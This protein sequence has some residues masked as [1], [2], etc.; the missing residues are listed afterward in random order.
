MNFEEE[1]KKKTGEVKKILAAYLPAPEGFQSRVLE[2]MEYAVSAGGKRERP[3]LMAETA[4]LFGE[5]GESLS[6][7]MADR[8]S[9]V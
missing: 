6:C 3:L 1:L 4:A 5:A 2:A 7:F 9:V 8:K